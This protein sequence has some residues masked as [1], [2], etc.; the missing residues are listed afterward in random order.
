M[1]LWK[2]PQ[3]GLIKVAGVLMM[4]CTV[5]GLRAL[6]PSRKVSKICFLIKKQL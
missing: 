1:W 4:Q 6:G 2:V 5:L 3:L